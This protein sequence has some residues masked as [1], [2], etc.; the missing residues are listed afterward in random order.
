MK[1][2]VVCGIAIALISLGVEFN[3]CLPA[4]CCSVEQSKAAQDF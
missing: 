4:S 3:L 1:N 2:S